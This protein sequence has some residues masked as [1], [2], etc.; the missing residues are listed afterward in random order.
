MSKKQNQ[1]Y[2]SWLLLIA[3]IAIILFVIFI[4]RD[5]LNLPEG[6]QI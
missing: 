4:A 5:K 6:G 3:P 1:N 2:Q